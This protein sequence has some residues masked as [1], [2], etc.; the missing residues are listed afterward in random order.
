MV[1]DLVLVGFLNLRYH[2]WIRSPVL[3]GGQI[4]D[5]ELFKIPASESY[6]TVDFKKQK[7]YLSL[8]TLY[9]RLKNRRERKRGV[10]SKK[11]KIDKN[12][13]VVDGY[14]KIINYFIIVN[15]TLILLD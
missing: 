2:S 9:P 4:E 12:S 11:Y 8:S 1:E 15:S 3:F 6:Y 10:V 14:L 7:N 13:N 5:P